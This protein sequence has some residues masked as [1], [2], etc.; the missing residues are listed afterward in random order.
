MSRTKG[1]G[2]GAGVILYQKCP[3]CHKKKAYYT[4]NDIGKS[5][6]CTACKEWFDSS[7]LIRLQYRSQLENKQIDE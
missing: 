5:F 2:W 6:K 4:Q 3:L 1:S 7:D